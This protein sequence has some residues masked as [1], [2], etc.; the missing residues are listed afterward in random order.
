MLQFPNLGRDAMESLINR[1]G[2]YLDSC[3]FSDLGVCLIVVL[4]VLLASALVMTVAILF[5]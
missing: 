5:H 2:A 1:I 3:K 4:T